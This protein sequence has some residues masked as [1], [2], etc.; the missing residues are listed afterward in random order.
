MIGEGG[1]DGGVAEGAFSKKRKAPAEGAQLN[2]KLK[3]LYV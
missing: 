2:A 1:D 3:Q